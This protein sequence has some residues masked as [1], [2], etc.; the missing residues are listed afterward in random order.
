M[1][2]CVISCVCVCVH[3][4]QWCVSVHLCVFTSVS[5]CVSVSANAV[6]GGGLGLQL[7]SDC[8]A[9]HETASLG[10]WEGLDLG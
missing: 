7:S 6:W 8:Y 9:A 1:C 4:C 5:V 2:W 10:K 3:G